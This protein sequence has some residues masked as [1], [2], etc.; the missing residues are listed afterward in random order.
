MKNF[1][2]RLFHMHIPVGT[3]IKL[4][5]CVCVCVYLWLWD[6]CPGSQWTWRTDTSAE[7]EETTETFNDMSVLLFSAMTFLF[8]WSSSHL[9]G[10]SVDVDW[11]DVGQ[12]WS[13]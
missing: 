12:V 3:D 10:V 13:R 4:K 2:R 1:T 9:D 5:V 11:G 8:H 7:P 6:I